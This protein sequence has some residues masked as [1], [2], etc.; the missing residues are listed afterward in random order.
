[1]NRS[2]RQISHLKEIAHEPYSTVNFQTHVRNKSVE[3]KNF[4][5]LLEKAREL[6]RGHQVTA[7]IQYLE[8][9]LYYD[10]EGA[11]IN[12]MLGVCHLSLEHCQ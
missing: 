11:E 9:G 8:R 6:Y 7:A 3:N 1:M 2:H 5:H 10:G 12:F 4:D